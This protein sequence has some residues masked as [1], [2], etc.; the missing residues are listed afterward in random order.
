M[1]RDLKVVE[2]WCN[3]AVAGEGSVIGGAEEVIRW[4]KV[5]LPRSIHA[6]EKALN[7][8]RAW[9]V[10]VSSIRDGVRELTRLPIWG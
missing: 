1:Q 8:G 3:Q 2:G 4:V 9:G 5:F 6:R 7:S 10:L